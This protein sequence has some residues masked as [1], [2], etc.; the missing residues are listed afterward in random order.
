MTQVL[1]VCPASLQ[2]NHILNFF[3]FLHTTITVNPLLSFLVL[4]G[5]S[6]IGNLEF[7]LSVKNKRGRE[8]GGHKRQVGA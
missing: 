5:G 7:G 2:T 8:G 6:L 3:E 4:G 1:L